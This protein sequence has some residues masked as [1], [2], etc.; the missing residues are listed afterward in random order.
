MRSFIKAL[1]TRDKFSSGPTSLSDFM[2]YREVCINAAHEERAFQTFRTNPIYNKILEHVPKEQGFDY[3]NL[4]KED[5]EIF[6][7]IGEFKK[8]DNYGGPRKSDYPAIGPVSPTT[9]RYI[10]VLCDLKKYFGSLDDLRIC[11]I[12]VGYGGQCRIIDAFFQPAKYVLVDLSPT[13]ALARRYLENYPLRS[14]VEFRTL[15]ELAKEGYDLVISNYA[16]SELVRSVQD[17]YLDKVIEESNQGY[18][19]YNQITPPEFGSYS[20]EKLC[21]LIPGSRISDEKPLTHSGNC[22]ISWSR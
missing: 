9:L 2:G 18:L 20:A 12:G 1:F 15:N 17:V 5:P 22:I 16:F 11:E 10:K 6:Q 7:K 21:E 14:V 4:I 8:N 19:T 3:L 13:L